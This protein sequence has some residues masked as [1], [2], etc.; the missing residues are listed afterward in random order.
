MNLFVVV[1]GVLFFVNIVFV[2]LG[3][4]FIVVG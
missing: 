3:L 2:I 1:F 4:I